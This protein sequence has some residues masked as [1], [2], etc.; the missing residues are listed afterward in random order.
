[1]VSSATWQI[2]SPTVWV[3]DVTTSGPSTQMFFATG[4]P[5]D[6]SGLTQTQATALATGLQTAVAALTGVTG[7]ALTAVA[8]SSPSLTLGTGS[9]TPGVQ[10][11]GSGPATDN[12]STVVS[13]TQ[14]LIVALVGRSGGAATGALS[15]VTD[16]QG[17]AWTRVARGSVPSVQYTRI[18]CWAAAATQPVTALEISLSS[19][20]ARTW[21]WNITSW[22]TAT[23]PLNVD[24]VSPDGSG[25]AS[26]STI[27]TPSIIPAFA[28]DLVIAAGHWPLSASTLA[29][30]G[31]TAMT[32]FDDGILGSTR[33]AYT[34]PGVTGAQSASWT[35][36]GGA[37]Q[38]GVLTVAF[39]GSLLGLPQPPA[40][41]PAPLADLEFASSAWSS[42]SGALTLPGWSS[43]GLQLVTKSPADTVLTLVQVNSIAAGLQTAAAALTGVSAATVSLQAVTPASV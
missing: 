42:Y 6:N 18:E 41:N 22:P 8:V 5:G 32:A 2:G 39:L 36:S 11:T 34:Q 10:V 3:L 7:C 25:V 31:W 13:G 23:G 20:V 33:A 24:A 38:A 30:S 16:S 28:G 35:L 15:T 21:S 17:N 9:V 37:Q 19:V 14:G 27:A 4:F 40:A 43:T 1:M 26:S 29:G 12:M